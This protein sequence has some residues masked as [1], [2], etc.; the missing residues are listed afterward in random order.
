MPFRSY[1]RLLFKFWTLRF[2][3][4]LPASGATYTV[5]LRLIEKLIVDFLFVLIELFR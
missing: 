4:P 3:P 1:R 5:H 2:E